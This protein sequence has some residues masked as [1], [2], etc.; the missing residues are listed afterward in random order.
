M[1]IINRIRGIKRTKNY[2]LGSLV[3]KNE[4]RNRV[5]LNFWPARDCRGAQNPILQRKRRNHSLVSWGRRTLDRC[6]GEKRGLPGE[7]GVKAVSSGTKR[8]SFLS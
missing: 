8:L 7:A 5:F 1:E 2:L 6:S 3:K 4:D